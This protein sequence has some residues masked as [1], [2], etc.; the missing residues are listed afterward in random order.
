[1]VKRHFGVF[2]VLA[3]LLALNAAVDAVRAGELGRDCH[4]PVARGA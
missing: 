4:G 2:V 3:V 1:M